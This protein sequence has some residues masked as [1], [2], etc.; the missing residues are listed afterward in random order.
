MEQIEIIL[1]S[2][3]PPA[4]NSP[5]QHSKQNKGHSIQSPEQSHPA[6]S[7]SLPPRQLASPQYTLDPPGSVTVSVF[8]GSV[9][10]GFASGIGIGIYTSDSM[11]DFS[12]C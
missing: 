7:Q 6:Q 11:T 10:K 8:K 1:L 9:F 2:G 3:Q 5:Q 12:I 4:L